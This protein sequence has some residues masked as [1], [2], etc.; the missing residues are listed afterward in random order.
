[1]HAAKVFHSN[2]VEIVHAAKICFREMKIYKI[3]R[4]NYYLHIEAEDLSQ[5]MIYA[6]KGE[7]QYSF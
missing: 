2:Y 4:Q 6:N 3:Q 7:K 1:M 5:A